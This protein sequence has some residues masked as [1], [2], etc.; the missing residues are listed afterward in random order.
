MSVVQWI[1]YNKSI[2]YKLKKTYRNI[3]VK[4]LG[5]LIIKSQSMFVN[6]TSQIFDMKSS[7]PA[8]TM[9]RKADDRN[10]NATTADLEKQTK[11]F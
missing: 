9:S 3:N 2:F 6:K 5:H 1:F 7:S 4:K 11:T 10:T 8:G